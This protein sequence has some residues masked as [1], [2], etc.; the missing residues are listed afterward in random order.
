MTIWDCVKNV[1][2]APDNLAKIETLS[3][4]FQEIEEK[5][6]KQAQEI[7]YHSNIISEL[8]AD[9]LNLRN[10]FIELL[11]MLTKEDGNIDLKTTVTKLRRGSKYLEK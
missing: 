1:F 10:L 4:K 11:Q 7:E 5:I 6:S 3:E 8:E 2:Q 9:I